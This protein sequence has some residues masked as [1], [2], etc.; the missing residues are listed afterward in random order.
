M[1]Y[2]QSRCRA[3][4]QPQNEAKQGHK[5]S[6]SKVGQLYDTHAAWVG[7]CTLHQHAGCCKM[8]VAAVGSQDVHM[9]PASSSAQ[10]WGTQGPSCSSL[11]RLAGC[12][13]GT[14][15]M[16]SEAIHCPPAPLSIVPQ[17]AL[18]ALVCRGLGSTEVQFHAYYLICQIQRHYAASPNSIRCVVDL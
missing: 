2:Q 18:P 13:G 1:A 15:M 5:H 10:T 11:P 3:G 9:L 7:A 12:S 8:A 14:H 16:T 6:M 4:V 17:Q